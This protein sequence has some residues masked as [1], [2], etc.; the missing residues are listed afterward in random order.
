MQLAD[1]KKAELERFLA[2]V[3]EEL[4]QHMVSLNVGLAGRNRA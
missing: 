3:C 1:T 4:E 2:T